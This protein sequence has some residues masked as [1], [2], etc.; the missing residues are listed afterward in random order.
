MSKLIEKLGV[1]KF[2][3]TTPEQPNQTLELN[4]NPIIKQFELDQGKQ[5]YKLIHWQGR[6]KG[7]RQWGIYDAEADSYMCGVFNGHSAM[8]GGSKLLMLPDDTT[9]TIPSAVVHFVGSLP[10]KNI[11]DSN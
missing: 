6:P 7:D 4:F 10:I 8:Y 11:G 5:N 2:R 3:V 9:K 1:G